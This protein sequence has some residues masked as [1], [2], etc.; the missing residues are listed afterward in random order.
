MPSSF[1]AALAVLLL[2]AQPVAA[3]ADSPLTIDALSYERQ[4]QLRCTMLAGVIVDEHE[5]GVADDARGLGQE[6]LER[7]GEGLAEVLAAEDGADSAATRA[8]LK[9]QFEDF[10]MAISDDGAEDAKARFDELATTCQPLWFGP[11]PLPQPPAYADKPV[12]AY[13]CFALNSAFSDA[14]VQG[15]GG[16]TPISMVFARRANRIEAGLMEKAGDDE[17]AAEQVGSDLLG[18]AADFDAVA[19]DALEERE[20]ETIMTWCDKLAGPDD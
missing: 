2:A 10:S 20:A 16:D 12:D 19:F 17:A 18:A 3:S 7:L 14:M 13:L 11:A 15:A 4:L 8:L 6:D 5:R 9:A 1:A